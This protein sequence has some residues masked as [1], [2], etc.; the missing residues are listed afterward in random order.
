MR[1]LP[2]RRIVLA[3][4]LLSSL[5][6]GSVRAEDNMWSWFSGEWSLTLGGAGYVAPRY[7]G[8]DDYHVT[9]MPLIS[10]G[11]KG[12]QTRFYSLNDSASFAVIDTGVFRFG[13]AAALVLPRDDNTSGDL[14]GLPD[15]PWGVELGAFM[16]VYPVDWMRVRAEVREGV[17]AYSGIVADLT[18]DAF[19]D[20]TPTLRLSGGPRLSLATEGYFDAYYGVTPAQSVASGLSVYDP[21]GG[22]RSAGVGGALTWRTTDKVTTSLF[23]EYKRLLG[24]AAD[25]S[26][27]EERGTKD[28]FTVGVSATYRFDFAM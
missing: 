15:V 27:V 8:S 12:S 16:D 26:L 3:A 5:A 4:A 10:L 1:L 22:L 2:S 21:D 6:G 20:L 28:Q 11:R 14:R 25:S 13:P 18:A 9:G 23:G 17:H 7:E 24:P 19:T